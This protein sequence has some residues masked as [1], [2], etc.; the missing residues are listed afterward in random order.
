MRLNTD[1]VK[2][3]VEGFDPENHIP[4]GK[5]DEVFKLLKEFLKGVK[6]P[7]SWWAQWKEK[8]QE[9]QKAKQAAPKEASAP[10]AEDKTNKGDDKESQKASILFCSWRSLISSW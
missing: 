4:K 3:E 2:T 9:A 6:E 10:E 1:A 5:Q 7:P 8:K